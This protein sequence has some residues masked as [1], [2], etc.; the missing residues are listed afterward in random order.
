MQNSMEQRTKLKSYV[1]GPDQDLHLVVNLVVRFAGSPEVTILFY[2]LS[3][4]S[5]R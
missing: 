4:I 2:E 3:L 1:R 5:R